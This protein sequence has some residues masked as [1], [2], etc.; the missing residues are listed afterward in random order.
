MGT[1]VKK[2]TFFFLIMR[3]YAKGHRRCRVVDHI[4][5]IRYT[6]FFFR[7]GNRV[8]FIYYI[9]LFAVCICLFLNF[10]F[11]Y[12]TVHYRLPVVFTVGS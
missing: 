4:L 12:G 11:K 8:R 7:I 5:Y 2:Y 9:R 1:R 6:G 3:L 10:F